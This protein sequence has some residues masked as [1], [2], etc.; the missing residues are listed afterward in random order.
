MIITNGTVIGYLNALQ[1]IS[2]VEFP[3]SITYAIK[4]NHRKLVSEYKDYEEQKNSLME[5]F[6]KVEKDP[7]YIKALQELLDIEVSVDFHMLSES[8]FENGDFN[9]TAAQ[10]EIL[11]FM[12]ETE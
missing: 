8:I 1:L 4:K 3:V 9:I 2:D 7:E 10:L 6:P 5:R 11:E 12:I